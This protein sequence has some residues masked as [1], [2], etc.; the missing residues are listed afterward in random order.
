MNKLS[1]EIFT[2]KYKN[3][4]TILLEKAKEDKKILQEELGLKEDEP[5]TKRKM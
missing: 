4:D 2:I 5:R 1:G 3:R